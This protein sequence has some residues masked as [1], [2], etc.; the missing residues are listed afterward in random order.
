MSFAPGKV[1]PYW[2]HDRDL[3]ADLER[4]RDVHRVDRLVL[5]IEDGELRDL[6]IE[7][8]PELAAAAGIE[9]VRYPIADFG[10][11]TDEA[12]FGPLVDDVL[13]RVQAGGRVVVACKGGYGRT[14]AVTG[15]ILRAAGLSPAEAVTTVRT[16]RPGTI[17]TDVQ[18]SFVLDRPTPSET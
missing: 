12:T 17:E 6:R 13:G 2:Q 9:L 11:P 8:L 1:D 16:T 7:A 5:L 14:G 15:A 4:M 3:A 10:I 18:A